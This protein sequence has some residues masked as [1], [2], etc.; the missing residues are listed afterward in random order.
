MSRKKIKD[1]GGEI[2]ETKQKNKDN[3]KSEAGSLKIST[4]SVILLPENKM[5]QTCKI[6]ITKIRGAGNNP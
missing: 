1:I 4:K 6:Q 5:K 3:A 2:T